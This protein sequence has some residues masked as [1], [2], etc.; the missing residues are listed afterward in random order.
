MSAVPKLRFPEFDGEWTEQKVRKITE[1][2][3]SGVTPKGGRESYKEAGFPLIRSQNV[4]GNKLTLDDVVFIDQA[5]HNRMSGSVVRNGD[6]LLNIT[7]ASIGRSCCVD[8]LETEANVNQHVCIIRLKSD[9]ASH[10]LQPIIASE[11]G[12]KAIFQAQSGSGRE[13]LNFENIGSFKFAFPSLPEQQKIAAFLS[14]VDKKIDLLRQKKDALELYKKGLMQKLFSQEIRFKQDDGSD[15]PDWEEVALGDVGEFSSAGVDKKI[16]PGE[17]EVRLLNFTNV[18][19][20]TK[21]F[22]ADLNQVVT[23]PIRKFEQCDVKK[24]DIFFT[25]SSETR[26][27]IG[28][29]AV[30]AE[31]MRNVVYSYHVVRFRLTQEWDFNF[32]CFAFDRKEFRKQCYLAGDGSG[33]RYVISQNAFRR[34]ILNIPILAEQ[35]KIGSALA[36]INSKIEKASSQIEQ[37]ETFK[38]GLLQQMFV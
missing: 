11:I 10:F 3:G 27:D 1:K 38:K 35:A 33:Q 25:P 2:I 7:G 24:G 4:N 36:A 23:A 21:I 22:D 37:M 6:I 13:G 20:Q 9:F 32:S 29:S 14:S 34:M 31:D 12:Q 30:A 26:D 8:G 16:V 15:F 17:E 28:L 5:Q 19:K 18:Y